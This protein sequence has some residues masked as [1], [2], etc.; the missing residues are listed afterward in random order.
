MVS[1]LLQTN[2][3]PPAI[4]LETNKRGGEKENLA[5][6]GVMATPEPSAVVQQ[7]N[8]TPNDAALGSGKS[9]AT[10]R[11]EQ[12]INVEASNL[13]Q[14]LQN[15]VHKSIQKSIQNL[16]SPITNV[17]E[18]PRS[19][20]VPDAPAVAPNRIEPQSKV[21]PV[22]PAPADPLSDMVDDPRVSVTQ[23]VSEKVII[24]PSIDS[25]R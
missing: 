1:R 20:A 6:K 4:Q 12:A 10:P 18:P 15:S 19:N 17:E 21:L 8:L 16:P 7:K 13:T 5:E 14:E 24:G 23:R 2:D 25:S 9:P 3:A 11:G 22:A